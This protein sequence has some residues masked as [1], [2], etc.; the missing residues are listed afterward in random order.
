[1]NYEPVDLSSLHPMHRDGKTYI[2]RHTYA[3]K[4]A[5]D[6]Y[7]E[8]MP[9]CAAKVYVLYVV[10]NDE[11]NVIDQKTHEFELQMK[12]GIPSMRV[13]FDELITE[14]NVDE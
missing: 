4:Q 12:Y 3:Y 8:T 14:M 9:A 5:V 7:K 10:S 13:T 1:M 2:D 11:R 6:F